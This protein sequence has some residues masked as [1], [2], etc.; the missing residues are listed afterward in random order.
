MV[1]NEQEIYLDLISRNDILTAEEI[2]DYSDV[3][4]KVAKLIASRKDIRVDDIRVELEAVEF[5]IVAP[6]IRSII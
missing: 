4:F 5:K 1:K 3:F 2:T 6:R